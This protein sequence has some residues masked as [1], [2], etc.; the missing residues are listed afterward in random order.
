VPGAAGGATPG[1]TG[2]AFGVGN[3]GEAAA[4]GAIPIE[5]GA[6]G[7]ALIEADGLSIT[8]EVDPLTGEINL[9][10]DNGD[11]TPE[12]YGVEFGEDTADS[13]AGETPSIPGMDNAV[14]LPAEGE[15]FAPGEVNALPAD[16]E[17]LVGQPEPPAGA[18]VAGGFTEPEFAAAPAADA[19]FAGGGGGGGGFDGGGGAAGGGIDGGAAGGGAAG[20]GFSEPQVSTMPAP[21]NSGFTGGVAPAA[22]GPVSG[23]FTEP[24]GFQAPA[25]ASSPSF[26][27]TGFQSP[28]PSEG[29]FGGGS[30][31]GFA[32]GS[33]GG[34]GQY[35]T[36]GLTSASGASVLGGGSGFNGADSVLGGGSSSSGSDN[37]WSS[38][39]SSSA[40]QGLASDTYAAQA[41]Q[42]GSATL[43]SM[44]ESQ[45]PGQPGG[46]AVGGGMMGGG[47]MGGGMA[48]GGQ[49]GGG[50][51]NERSSP[52]QWRTTGS[53]FDDDVSLSRVQGVLGEEGR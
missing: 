28:G 11:G 5:A 34:F 38:P 36:E 43:P 25:A 46:S 51:D 47:M 7:K 45:T 27:A 26:Q 3:Q 22:G 20:G 24:S 8:A 48:G 41:G 4:N 9:T 29:G 31:G 33:G 10:V 19:G 32:G 37:T 52:G 49:Q 14:P 40:D 53:L 21:D 16:A 17:S 15:P 39:P 6:D 35:N 50:G 1:S 13:G 18:A 42:A 23:G 2:A 12:E 30:G 44:Q